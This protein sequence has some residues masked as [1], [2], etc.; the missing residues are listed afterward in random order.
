MRLRVTLPGELIERI[1]PLIWPDQRS[2]FLTDAATRALKQAEFLA[3][4]REMA[5]SLADYDAPGWETSESAAQWVH[6]L[7]YGQA[8][9]YEH[10]DE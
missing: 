2:Q 9:I 3:L 1:D 4:A 6:R 7:C 5:G 8:S 10:D